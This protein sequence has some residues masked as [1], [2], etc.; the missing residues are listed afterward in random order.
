[1]SMSLAAPAARSLQGWY[2]RPSGPFQLSSEPISLTY[3]MQWLAVERMPIILGAFLCLSLFLG[4]IIPA[5]AFAQPRVHGDP[6][7]RAPR[8]FGRLP[9]VLTS[10]GMRVDDIKNVSELRPDHQIL[11]LI[12][13]T[14]QFT[15]DEIKRIRQWVEGGGGLLVL[16]D[17]TGDEVLRLPVNELL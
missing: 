6:S 10:M 2:D 5:P 9:P 11:F 13:L 14:K 1:Q 4:T 15:P 8:M 12:N 7:L 16:T 3:I 17:H